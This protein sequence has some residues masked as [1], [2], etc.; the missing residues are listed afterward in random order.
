MDEYIKYI[1]KMFITHFSVKP[2]L[3]L[4]VKK[5]RKTFKHVVVFYIDNLIEGRLKYSQ[6][7]CKLY[8]FVRGPREK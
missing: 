4:F 8:S 7:V 6:F 3:F 2:Y 1:D 5:F